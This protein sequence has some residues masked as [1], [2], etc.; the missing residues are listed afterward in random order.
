MPLAQVD[1]RYLAEHYNRRFDMVL[2][3]LTS[4]PQLHEE[5]DI[6]QALKSMRAVLSPSGIL[7]LSQGLT[8]KQFNA[9]RRFSLVNDSHKHTRMMVVDYLDTH[10]LVHVLD[11]FRSD[12]DTD[13]QVHSFQYRTLLEDDYRG[14]LKQTG[15]TRVEIYG[16]YDLA[17]YDKKKSNMM[18]I[19]ARQ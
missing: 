12:P 14:L 17:A 10:W 18:I 13:F 6:T 1:F 15:F 7:V 19:V 16:G 3:L 2:C 8:D 9:Q 11:C 4:L 5:S